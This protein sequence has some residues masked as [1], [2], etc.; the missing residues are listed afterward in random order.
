MF[1]DYM[2]YIYAIYEE[3][4]FSK[5]SKKL[6]V[7]QPWL[8]A[9][10]K[11]VEQE[12]QM[13]IFNRNTTPISLTEA[14]EYYI[15]AIEKVMNIQKEMEEHFAELTTLSK[16]QIHIGSSMFF[17]TYVLP[18]VLS[19]F[20]DQYPQITIS[21]TEGDSTA[22][23]EKLQAGALDFILEAEDI[24]TTSTESM[25]WAMEE[26]VLAVPAKAAVNKKLKEYMY[27]SEE[28]LKV[29]KNEWYKPRVPLSFFKEEQFLLLKKGND[30]YKRAL[31]MCKNAQFT[32]QISTYLEQMMTAY[33]L[34]SEGRGITFLRS[35]IPK[36]LA[37][38]DKVVFYCV[39]D[40]LAT[41]TIYL[42]YNKKNTSPVQRNLLEYMKAQE[43]VSTR[44]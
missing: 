21:Y 15:E 27:T 28:L 6:F 5:A 8:S 36:F 33:Y 23:L 32:P 41:R 16:T 7:S 4:S 31:K 22:M 34:V 24:T 42:S 11:K 43:H 25:P 1:L 14:G 10:V 29:N 2:E 13:P 37:P 39:D 38:N 35:T 44:R 18:E 17:C 30:S 20:R 40:P 3:K 19:Y 12:I 9:T 26:I